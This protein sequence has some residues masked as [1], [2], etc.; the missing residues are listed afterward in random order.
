MTIGALGP[1][2]AALEADLRT[3]VRGTASCSGSTSTNHYTGFV[4]RLIGAASDGSL[5]YE[6]HAFRGQ[7]P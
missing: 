7:P 6:V 3:W 2:S 5:P 4:D 1:V